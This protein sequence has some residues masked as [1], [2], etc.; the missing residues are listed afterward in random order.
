MIILVVSFFVVLQQLQHP[1]IPM[2]LV[3]PIMLMLKALLTKG[4]RFLS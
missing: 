2:D 1:L 4:F 3:E